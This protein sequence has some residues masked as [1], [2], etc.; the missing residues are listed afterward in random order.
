VPLWAPYSF[1]GSPLLANGQPGALDPL[2]LLYLAWSFPI[3]HTFMLALQMLMA[4]LF[5]FWFLRAL[6]VGRFG[7][8]VGAVAWM[9]NAYLSNWREHQVWVG[10]A[11][12]LP[13]A[14]G[15]IEVGVQRRRPVFGV[16]AGVAL[17]VSLF[18]GHGNVWI[19][20]TLFSF[21][22]GTARVL[23]VREWR[24]AA[25]VVV[26]VASV[27]GVGAIQLF[28]FLELA[29][30]A[31]RP[32][33]AS[34][35][36]LLAMPAYHLATIV[37]PDLF[38]SPVRN[39]W[40]PMHMAIDLAW[41]R[42]RGVP[43][44]GLPPGNY[45]EFCVYFG[46]LPLALALVGAWSWRRR[47]G[48]LLLAL[49]GVGAL[50][51]AL[52]TPLEAA[53]FHLVPGMKKLAAC[54]WLL[55]SG[56]CGCAL[57]GLG[58]DALVN[59]P[60]TLRRSRGA[61]A[62]IVLGAVEG[63]VA[64]A[65]R[66]LLGNEQV[67]R[68]WVQRAIAA[69]VLQKPLD[70]YLG[71]LEWLWRGL[72]WQNESLLI[73]AALLIAAG[74]MLLPRARRAPRRWW[75]AAVL[76]VVAIDLIAFGWRVN[77]LTPRSEVLPPTPATTLLAQRAAVE[78]PFRVV[79]FDD[80]APPNTYAWYGLSSVAGNQSL[81]AGRYR[82]LMEAGTGLP[83][84]VI[85]QM[86]EPAPALTAML[87]V[88]YLLST[89]PLDDPRLEEVSGGP[90]RIYRDPRALSQVSV[91]RAVVG[92]KTPAQIL[93]A[94][95]AEGF[96]PAETAYVEGLGN[97]ERQSPEKWRVR[98]SRPH[99]ETILAT[100]AAPAAGIVLLSESYDAGWRAT[101][102]GEPVAMLRADYALSAVR[103]PAGEHQVRWEYRPRSYDVGRGV[104]LISLAIALLLAAVEIGR[105]RRR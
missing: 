54:R 43:A 68:S 50:L 8:A 26:A 5:M 4:G 62:L 78:D 13:L 11:L 45:N 24:A 58:A 70:H 35:H 53:L 57:A 67:A 83:M 66:V 36:Q 65:L 12:Y 46:I 94:V 69:G 40:D 89:K 87:N 31:Q 61:V 6:R 51:V 86:W 38:G 74:I 15:L 105:G 34:Y 52:G 59:A 100:V 49:L 3:A 22:Y 81:Y 18:S 84:P 21:V 82:E 44:V 79:A 90:T 80:V 23:A 88:R 27:V 75:Q 99:A 39:S 10:A 93:A 98:V 19:I 42:V 73:S 91:P 56:F 64:L 101:V 47:R 17:A 41:S 20:V 103:V 2:N 92:G 14:L 7:A 104:T 16:W 48:A 25:V 71:R 28:P 29:R 60:V 76:G 32:D 37:S 95:T 72:S 96:D 30:H 63:I 55:L 9:F 33:V 102:D 85:V 97:N 77:S 1:S